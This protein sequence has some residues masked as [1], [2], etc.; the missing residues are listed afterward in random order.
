MN[1]KWHISY[2]GDWDYE[3]EL[4]PGEHDNYSCACVPHDMEIR[5]VRLHMILLN[6]KISSQA[7]GFY[8]Y[9][10]MNCID[11]HDYSVEV[12]N[13]AVYILVGDRTVESCVL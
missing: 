7:D 6:L 2:A 10:Y 5:L 8:C 1:F 11:G 13:Y 12:T 3:K 9:H 4:G